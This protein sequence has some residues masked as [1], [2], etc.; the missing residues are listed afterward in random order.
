MFDVTPC[1]FLFSLKEKF[2]DMELI[3]FCDYFYKHLP[4]S[5]ALIAEYKKNVMYIRKKFR[6]VTI[7]SSAS[8]VGGGS[9]SYN[10]NASQPSPQVSKRKS[11]ASYIGSSPSSVPSTAFMDKYGEVKWYSTFLSSGS[12]DSSSSSSPQTSYMWLLKPTNLNRG[13]GI[14]IFTNLN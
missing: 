2:W 10:N 8:P 3:H 11:L 1:T 13:R 6:P 14:E 4:A 12:C 7:R 5:L 9:K